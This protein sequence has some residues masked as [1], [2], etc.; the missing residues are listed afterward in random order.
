MLSGEAEWSVGNPYN[1]K[2]TPQGRLSEREAGFG[3]LGGPHIIA[4]VAEVATR[5]L[6]V[7]W[8]QKWQVHLRLRPEAYGGLLHVQEVGVGKVTR[9][10]GLPAWLATTRA[11]GDIRKAHGSLLL[12][13]AF[14]PG[15]PTHPAYGAGHATVAGACVTLLK[16]FFRMLEADGTP[17][18]FDTLL[19]RTQPF[20]PKANSTA[21]LTGRDAAGAGAARCAVR[22]RDWRS[23]DRG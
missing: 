14:T 6:K 7:V 23:D 4:L 2:A 13:M 1:G 9:T 19:E 20:G 5:A 16:A 12:P 17:R 15:S 11:A 22:R 18:R 3:V 10:Y 8:N 21:Y